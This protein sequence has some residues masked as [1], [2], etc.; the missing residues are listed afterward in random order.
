MYSSKERKIFRFELNGKRYAYDPLA[1]YRKIA[2]VSQEKEID[3][4]AEM[5]MLQVLDFEHESQSGT[6][7]NVAMQ[8]L[9]KVMVL[10][11]EVLNLPEFGVDDTGKEIGATDEEMIGVMLSFVEFSNDL[12]K[13]T[14][15]PPSSQTTT[16][17]A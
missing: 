5:K 1:L 10:F 14:E 11:R 16:P 8:S 7:T 17:A 3:L 2:A 4:E 6:L 12:K 9:D 15:R 13:N